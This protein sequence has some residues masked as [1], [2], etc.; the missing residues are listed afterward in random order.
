[1]CYDH[2]HPKIYLGFDWYRASLHPP[3]R[4]QRLITL[5]NDLCTAIQD[6]ILRSQYTSLVFSLEFSEA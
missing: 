1:M 5:A 3:V 4:T 2:H 6:S